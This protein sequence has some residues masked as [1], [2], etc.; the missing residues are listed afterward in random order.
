MWRVYE[1]MQILRWEC[2]QR[3]QLGEKTDES[4]TLSLSC[5]PPLPLRV[6]TCFFITLC[7]HMLKLSST[8]EGQRCHSGAPH[9]CCIWK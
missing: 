1:E 9:H 2:V 8:Y 4:A 7:C 3:I 6:Q 5:L